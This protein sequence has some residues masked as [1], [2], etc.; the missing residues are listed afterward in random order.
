[1]LA[2]DYNQIESFVVLDIFWHVRIVIANFN[3]LVL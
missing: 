3:I 2:N 1:M